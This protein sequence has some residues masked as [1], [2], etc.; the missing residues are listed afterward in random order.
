M[1]LEDEGRAFLFPPFANYAEYNLDAAA[2]D[3]IPHALMGLG[4][5]GAH[6]GI[7][8]DASYP[9]YLLTALG[10]RS[11][12]RPLRHPL[13]G[14]APDPD[15]ARAVGLHDRGVIAP[16]KKA[17][18]NV[19]DF[20]KL[21]S[22]RP[23]WRS[24]CRPAASACCRARRLSRHHRVGR[25]HLSRWRGHRR[26]AGQAGAR[27]AGGAAI[28]QEGATGRISRPRRV[29]VGRRTGVPASAT[30]GSGRAGLT[31]RS[32]RS[33]RP[34]AAPR[35]RWML[36]PRPTWR[37]ASRVT[38]SRCCSAKT[39]GSRLAAPSISRSRLRHAPGNRRLPCLR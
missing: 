21:A 37:C 33:M 18:I 9:T 10:P 30:R 27:P 26:A 35:Q 4:D 6:V 13:S 23:S 32:G 39:A 20:D 3:R 36:L 25:R 28:L 8:S 1:L 12:P 22:R 11:Q 7:I 16:G 31:A 24:T 14:Q 38:S 5:G 15:T 17:D 29:K 34:S 19:I 2:S